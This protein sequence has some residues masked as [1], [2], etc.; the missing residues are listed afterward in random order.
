MAGLQLREAG[1]DALGDLVE[2]PR[3]EDQRIIH[4]GDGPVSNLLGLSREVNMEECALCNGDVN[5]Q[6]LWFC[7]DSACTAGICGECVEK[8]GGKHC[9]F[10]QNPVSRWQEQPQKILDCL[11]KI[12]K[13]A[14]CPGCDKELYGKSAYDAHVRSCPHLYVSC[15]VCNE[16][17]SVPGFL[18]HM[19]CRHQGAGA[20]PDQLAALVKLFMEGARPLANGDHRKRDEAFYTNN[21]TKI[22][23]CHGFGKN[24]RAKAYRVRKAVRD[25]SQGPGNWDGGIYFDP[26]TV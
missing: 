25:Q 2:L 14:P 7:G 4:K 17:V 9:S 16:P 11:R 23:A 19:V 13:M 8:V 10:C 15:T 18:D 24:A 26:M 6:P 3:Y 5:E 20:T 12:Q 1:A 22:L 21:I